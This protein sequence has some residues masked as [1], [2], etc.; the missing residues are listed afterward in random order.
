[1]KDEIPPRWMWTVDH[2]LDIWFE[3]VERKREEKFGTG[4][5]SDDEPAGPMMRNELADEIRGK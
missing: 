5:S 4:G 2:D 1:M 3:E